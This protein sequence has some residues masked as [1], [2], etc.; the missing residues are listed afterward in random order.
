MCCAPKFD[1]SLWQRRLREEWQQR[2]AMRQAVLAEVTIRLRDYFAN[3]RVEE[4]YLVGSVLQEGAFY[5]FS[6]IDVAVKGLKE[7]YFRTLADLME[8]LDRQVDLIEYEQVP[9]RDQIVQRGLKIK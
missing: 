2:E 9:F 4:V 8:L 6:D 7:D 5:P 3:K 1:T